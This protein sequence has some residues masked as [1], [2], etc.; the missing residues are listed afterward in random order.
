MATA[1]GTARGNMVIIS[2]FLTVGELHYTV[3]FLPRVV[4]P[5]EFLLPHGVL[6][7]HLLPV[8]AEQLQGHDRVLRRILHVEHRTG[9]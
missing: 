7:D 5:H 4:L 6:C 8:F 3:H 1:T 9:V 2:S